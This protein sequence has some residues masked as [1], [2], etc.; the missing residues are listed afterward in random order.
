MKKTLDPKSAEFLNI[1]KSLTN[2]K[3]NLP[4]LTISNLKEIVKFFAE[5]KEVAKLFTDKLL[6]NKFV[7]FNVLD[8]GAHPFKIRIDEKVTLSDN[9]MLDNDGEFPRED[10]YAN[11][12]LLFDNIKTIWLGCGEYDDYYNMD[13]YFMGNTALLI[14]GQTC[15]SVASEIIEFKL[16]EGEKVTRYISTVGNSGVP[17]GWIETN[18]GYYA[19]SSFN[20]V[21]GVLFLSNKFEI[22]EKKMNC[23]ETKT[24]PFKNSKKV[25]YK[26]L[27]PRM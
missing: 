9:T 20:C 6:K 25:P 16:S 13:S 19:L 23:W 14:N 26:T 2:K 3:L 10:K 1:V 12:S 27:V 5:N 4:P 24:Y 18:L 8:N 21:D 15:I 7:D 11:F 22:D 17:Y